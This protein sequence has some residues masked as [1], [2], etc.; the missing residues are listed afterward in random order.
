MLPQ[1]NFHTQYRNVSDILKLQGNKQF[2]I[3]I[4]AAQYL[5]IAYIAG[6]IAKVFY[7]RMPSLDMLGI[8]R[9]I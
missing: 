2:G 1:S 7:R 8:H 9:Y 5:F 3:A 4:I 6:H